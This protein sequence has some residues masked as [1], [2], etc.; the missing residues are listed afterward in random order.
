MSARPVFV[1][2]TDTG[3]GKTVLTALL[4]LHAQSGAGAKAVAMKPFC[5]GGREDAELLWK[6]Q[7]GRQALDAINPFCFTE[8]LSPWTAAR[9]AGRSI[10]LEETLG[11]IRPVSAELLLI[12]GAGGLLAPLGDGFSAM[13]I[14]RALE[15]EVIIAA[16]NR[17][18]VISQTLLTLRHLQGQ[19]VRDARIALIDCA[20]RDPSSA[21]NLADLRQLAAPAPVAAIP[22]LA[23]RETVEDLRRAAESLSPALELLLPIGRKRASGT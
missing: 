11:A 5:S 20:P 15:A 21:H 22:W 17:I 1:T 2:G 3:V 23:A 9:L 18:G 14:I 10:T 12:E 16:P 19:G 4:L 8:P 6:L 7:G 13:E